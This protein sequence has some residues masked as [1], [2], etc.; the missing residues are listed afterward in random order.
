MNQIESTAGSSEDIE[1]VPPP[2]E[3]LLALSGRDYAGL[4]DDEYDIVS[5]FLE[6]NRQ[7]G[8]RVSVLN[9]A[10]QEFLQSAKTAKE[11]DDIVSA[12][13]HIVSASIIDGEDGAT[14]SSTTG[15]GPVSLDDVLSVARR[16]GVAANGVVFELADVRRMLEATEH[17]FRV[18]GRTTYGL[19]YAS[20]AR[21][22]LWDMD[23]VRTAVLTWNVAGGAIRQAVRAIA[24]AAASDDFKGI[25]MDC[26]PVLWADIKYLVEVLPSRF[27]PLTRSVPTEAWLKSVRPQEISPAVGGDAG[28]WK[29]A[30]E[31]AVGKGWTYR[32]IGADDGELGP[33]VF[34]SVS[35][36][37]VAAMISMVG[38]EVEYLPSEVVRD[39]IARALA[40]TGT[41]GSDGAPAR[42]FPDALAR[43]VNYAL[44]SVFSWMN[45]RADEPEQFMRQRIAMLAF[46]G[47][48][49]KDIDV[50]R[51]GELDY[52]FATAT[53][54]ATSI[55][56][57]N[58]RLVFTVDE[59]WG[60]SSVD[61]HDMRS[62]GVMLL[63][64]FAS[65]PKDAPRR[66]AK[67]EHMAR[68]K[69]RNDVLAKRPS[70]RRSGR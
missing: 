31:L 42:L 36:E 51:L 44:L 28:A 67:A 37:A 24:E 4:G 18:A 64:H 59:A 34:D 49:G 23:V 55:M 69:Y 11:Y 54:V 19:A 3:S 56:E 32:V 6:N 22:F 62:T 57:A 65:N 58:R 7:A 38:G 53:A 30:I 35:P 17:V 66:D 26:T 12:H 13:P 14:A 61:A 60:F 2:V 39:T 45:I 48:Q 52:F 8:V 9:A 20:V 16:L 41:S 10:P 68:V 46:H 33:E 50:S 29:S 27:G 70:H 1:F 15:A 5:F 47:I 63:Q 25:A 43:V 40:E 21:R